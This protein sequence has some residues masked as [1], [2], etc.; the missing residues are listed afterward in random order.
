MQISQVMDMKY[1]ILRDYVIG[2]MM[3][4][5]SMQNVKVI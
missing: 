4:F 1:M 5:I 3:L 2:Q